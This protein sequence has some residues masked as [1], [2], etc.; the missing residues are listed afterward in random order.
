VSPSER[1]KR[2]WTRLRPEILTETRIRILD[3]PD[4]R[5]SLMDLSPGGIGLIVDPPQESPIDHPLRL[6]IKFGK[7]EKVVRQGIVRHCRNGREFGFEWPSEPTPWNGIE[8]RN[9]QRLDLEHMSLWGRI[10]VPH[11]HHVWSR[12]RVLEIDAELGLRVQ[13]V[14]GPG[15]LLPGHVARI[16][17]DL[18]FAGPLSWECQVL[19]CRPSHGQGTLMGLRL[20]DLDVTLLEAL[21]QWLELH[22]VRSPLALQRLGFRRTLPPGQFRFRKVEAAEELAELDG[23][24]APRE[25]STDRIRIGC[26]EGPRLVGGA[27]MVVDPGSDTCS[28]ESI[29]LHPEWLVPDAFL[30]L[31]EQVIR[32]FLG[33]GTARLRLPEQEGLDRIVQLLGLKRIPGSD[34]WIL[35]RASVLFGSGIGAIRW[36]HL[37]GE[38]SAFARGGFETSRAW[39]PWIASLLR[40]GL[41]LLLR[42]WR[43]PKIRRSLHREIELWARLLENR[44]GTPIG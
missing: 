4:R 13:T 11:A 31:W 41:W 35:R 25:P 7:Q 24:L 8:R 3:W 32:H 26:W 39:R 19:W 29:Y 40:T 33:T 27:D 1:D 28:L 12:V 36:R 30:G 42:D 10:P 18:A 20:L 21:G 43:E 15:Y 34:G 16:H 23:L 5:V 17:L 2:R 22:R 6:E 14:G 37:Y 9:H 44:Q 38:V